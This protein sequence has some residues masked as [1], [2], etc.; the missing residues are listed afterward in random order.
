LISKVVN[1]RNITSIIFFTFW[2]FFVLSLF[3]NGFFYFINIPI[4]YIYLCFLFLILI[5]LWILAAAWLTVFERQILGS[6]QHRKGPNIVGFFG[7][8]QPIAD[9]F[10]LLTKEV[11]IPW[12]AEH[13]FFIYAAISLLFLSLILWIILSFNNNVMI[14]N[15]NVAILYFFSVSSLGIYGVII[16]GWASNSRYAFLGSLRACAQMLSYE[17]ILSTIL[18][19]F[20]IRVGSLT[21]VEIMNSY[22][23]NLFTWYG[24]LYFPLFLI[25]FVC[26]L[27]ETNRAPFDLPE[28]ESELVSGYNVDYSSIVFAFFFLG[29][30]LHILLMSNIIVILFLG[31]WYAPCSLFINIPSFFLYY[32]KVSVIFFSFIWVRSSLPRFRYDQLMTF[33][34]KILLPLTFS[35][36]FFYL[37]LIFF[38]ETYFSY[39]IFIKV[40]VFFLFSSCIFYKLKNFITKHND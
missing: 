3:F 22:T 6:I 32:C 16:A 28:A 7:L 23:H 9:A 34:W 17:L 21:I 4:I 18:L 20:L 11:I 27:A 2:N 35:L 10:K 5:L 26:A 24:I 25:F 40:L 12:R 13:L 39:I 8:L 38:F 37:F 19:F 30:Y 29:E 1:I 33:G 14:L 15:L 36:I 31:G